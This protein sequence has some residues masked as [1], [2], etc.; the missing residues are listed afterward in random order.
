MEHLTTRCRSP[1]RSCAGIAFTGEHDVFSGPDPP[2]TKT[3]T[4][5]SM[6]Q[7][8]AKGPYQLSQTAAVFS[9]TEAAQAF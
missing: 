8:S 2:D 7:T 4:F 5:G 3:Q 6:Y 9:S 1:P